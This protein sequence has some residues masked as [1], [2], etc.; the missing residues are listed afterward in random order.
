MK[1]K[2]CHVTQKKIETHLKTDVNHKPLCS[3][4]ILLT[5]LRFNGLYQ[6]NL[7]NK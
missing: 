2:L 5:A 1:Q 3:Y 4:M 7:G 6:R